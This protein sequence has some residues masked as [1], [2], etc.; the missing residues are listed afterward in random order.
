MTTKLLWVKVKNDNKLCVQNW[1]RFPALH[2]TP[3]MQ[4]VI[5]KNKIMNKL[6]TLTIIL[7]FSGAVLSDGE[8]PFF[9]S[10]IQG[11]SG[12]GFVSLNGPGKIDTEEPGSQVVNYQKGIYLSIDT[13]QSIEKHEDVCFIFF[14]HS[15]LREMG[16]KLDHITVK[17]Q[18]C[19]DVIKQIK[20]AK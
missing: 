16:S 13:I 17:K 19:N 8:I 2:Y 6:I 3:V 7:L 4:N 5:T 15:R 12:S 14:E 10:N 11:I 18:S 9:V 1:G 20:I